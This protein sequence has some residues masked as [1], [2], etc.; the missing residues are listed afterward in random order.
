MTDMTEQ[1]IIPEIRTERLLL[2][3]F[4]EDD[5]DPFAQMIADP[6]VISM[7]TYHG[8]PMNRTQAWNWLCMML[9]HWQMRG[10]GIWG[11][12]E[13]QS[14]ELIGRVGLQYLDWF[15]DVE[16]A[17]MLRKASWGKGYAAEASREAIRYGFEERSLP[18]IAAVIHIK[19]DRS[20]KLAER[21]DMVREKEIEREGVRFYQYARINA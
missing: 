12:E 2:R 5:L 8:Q 11:V 16:L 19:N 1:M 10:F 3:A 14:G 21:L 13:I 18:R 7:A 20:L 17:W 4:Q 6:Q 9:G 15:D